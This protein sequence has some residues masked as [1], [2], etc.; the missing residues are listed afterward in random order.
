MRALGGDISGS[1]RL[2]AREHRT[3]L[4]VGA[5]FNVGLAVRHNGSSECLVVN[6]GLHGRA[7]GRSRQ[8]IWRLKGYR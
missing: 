3:I 2:A 7:E 8:N 5:I 4:D 1:G 6:G